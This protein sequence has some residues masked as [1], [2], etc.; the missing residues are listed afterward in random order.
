VTKTIAP[1]S[2][3]LSSVGANV[4]GAYSFQANDL[5]E[6]SSFAAL[7]DQ[8]RFDWIEIQ[9]FPLNQLP[10]ATAGTV[11][12]PTAYIAIDYDDDTAPTSVAQVLDYEN[13][14]FMQCGQKF[15]C[16]FKPHVNLAMITATPTTQ[17]AGSTDNQWIDVS[18]LNI[19]HFGVKYALPSFNMCSS[20][21]VLFR[22]TMS[23]KNMR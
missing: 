14:N 7:Y 6:I 18:T 4:Y 1:A 20:W 21:Q 22:Y 9:L 2:N 11:Q 8:Y 23:F 10:T 16:R 19:K 3:M 17:S 5:T 12:A 15:N 13:V